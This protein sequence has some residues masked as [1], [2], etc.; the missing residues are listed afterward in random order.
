[1]GPGL[2]GQANRRPFKGEIRENRQNVRD[3]FRDLFGN[4]CDAFG[5]FGGSGRF[6]MVLEACWMILADFEK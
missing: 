3:L 6:W 4:V 5:I 2:L 1:M